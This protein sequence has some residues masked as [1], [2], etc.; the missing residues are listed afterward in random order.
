MTRRLSR[1]TEPEPDPEENHEREEVPAAEEQEEHSGPRQFPKIRDALLDYEDSHFQHQFDIGDKVLEEIGPPG[2]DGAHNGSG[3]G[4]DECSAWLQDQGLEYSPRTLK[5]WRDLA[6]KVP[7]SIRQEGEEAG[8]SIS[9]IQECCGDLETL[10]ALIAAQNGKRPGKLGGLTT[11]YKGEEISLASAI[12]K[13][14]RILVSDAKIALGRQ[15]AGGKRKSTDQKTISDLTVEEKREALKELTSDP[16]V[17]A[18][19]D[20]RADLRQEITE[21]EHAASLPS[22]PE[23]VQENEVASGVVGKSDRWVT[24]TEILEY[25]EKAGKGF[26][27]LEDQRDHDLN[28]S[29]PD[30]VQTVKLI[31]SMAHTLSVRA[32]LVCSAYGFTDDDI[33]NSMKGDQ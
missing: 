17:L 23:R 28:P 1:S 33:L 6:Y 15:S 11:M 30:E 19:R 4:F 5:N 20:T 14:G 24:M 8:V 31:T 16:E 13:R 21:A 9:V 18:D 12:C 2:K 32:D 29:N 27:E 7:P 26:D 25:L 22:N 3:D 10:K